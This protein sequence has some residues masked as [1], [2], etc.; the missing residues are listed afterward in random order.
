MRKIFFIISLCFVL[1]TLSSSALA[2]TTEMEQRFRALDAR[3]EGRDKLLQRDLKA[4]L[5]AYPYTTFEDE[6]K[7]MQGILQVEKGHYKQGLKILEQVEIYA[8]T[9]PRQ[10]DYAFYRG[11]A[12]LMIQEYQR[13]SIYFGQLSKGESRYAGRGAYYYA[14]C[15]YKLQKYDKALPALEKLENSPEYAKTVPYYLTQIHYAQ[16]NY[17]EAASR[18]ETLLRE[19]PENLNNGEL[20]RILGEM[21]YAQKDY[22]GTVEH[23]QQY[24]KAAK[25]NKEEYLRNDMYMLGTAEYQLGHYDEAVQALKLMKQEKDSLSEA[26]CLAMGNAYV[27]LDQLEQA[28]LS[29]QAAANYDITPAVTEEATY[30]YTLCTYR[31]SSALGES[32]RAFNDFLHQFPNSKY[33]SHIYQ[34]LS[35][36]LMQSKN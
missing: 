23:L 1:C 4:Y 35:D 29:Y 14:Y 12:Y 16:G 34:L 15:M 20:H 28:K 9:R 8:L 18:A 30:N 10:E 25:A 19:H 5:Q 24:Q 36:A 21:K 6:V 22:A 17:E 31:S 32:V 33:E 26:A 13:A 27:Q 11:Y 7:C 3:F 2:Q